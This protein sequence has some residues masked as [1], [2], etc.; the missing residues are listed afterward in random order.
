MLYY[1]AIGLT[2]I[3]NLFYHIFQKSIPENV[4]PFV[5]LIATYISAIVVSL[6]VFL[7]YPGNSNIPLTLKSLNW[8]SF[9]LGI[10]IVGLEVGFLLAYRAGWNLS[11]A[12]AFSNVAVTLLLIPVGIILFKEKLS[13]I[14]ITGLVFCVLGL[15][16]VNYK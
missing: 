7:I 11:I 15:I 12:A 2:I 5:S 9:A 13:V 8:A 4:N 1:I 6:A 3:A 10:A 16:L 14:N